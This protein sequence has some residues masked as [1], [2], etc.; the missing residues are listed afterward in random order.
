MSRR[1]KAPLFSIVPKIESARTA[2]ILASCGIL[3]VG[4]CST[5]KK[6]KIAWATAIQVKPI[7]P[8]QIAGAA[9]RETDTKPDLH[10][11]MPA[12]PS[13]LANARN[14]PVRPRVA[15]PPSNNGDN[16]EKSNPLV[17]VPQL[18]PEETTASQ[19]Q[20]NQSIEIAE[21]NLAACTGKQMNALQADQASKTRGFVSDARAAAHIGDW[22]RARALAK[23]AEVISEE[24]ASSF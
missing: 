24:L 8:A 6:P 7:V 5:R 1:E 22:R 10:L 23:K 2:L 12:P 20:T 19:Q 16:A 13:H 9:D 17:I 4:G 14:V 11:E 15:P 18:T 3:F 21:R